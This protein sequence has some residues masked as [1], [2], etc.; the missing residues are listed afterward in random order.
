[1]R[2]ILKKKSFFLNIS[3]TLLY[4]HTST[5]THTHPHTGSSSVPPS[6]G[7]GTGKGGEAQEPPRAQEHQGG[8]EGSGGQATSLGQH[9]DTRP[10]VCVYAP[11]PTITP[12]HMHT[13]THTHTQGAPPPGRTATQHVAHSPRL[14]WCHEQNGA[15]GFHCHQPRWKPLGCALH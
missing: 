12:S 6:G 1:M 4:T 8:Q 14:Q 10:S 9:A 7:W 2:F 13:Y 5:H 15:H 3:N 11:P